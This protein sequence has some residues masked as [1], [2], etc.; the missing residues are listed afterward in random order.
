MAPTKTFRVL[1][2]DGG[3]MRGTY[4]ATYLGRVAADFAKKRGL[5]ELDVGAAFDLVVGTSTGG[6]IA[7]A[8]VA[9]VP[10]ERVAALY[11]DHGKAIFRRPL[12][13]RFGPRLFA[14]LFVRPRAVELGTA[15]LREGLT[16]CFGDTTIEDVYA[17][18]RIALAITAVELS[19]HRSWIFKTPH[20][21]N[22]NGRDNRYTLVNVCLATT[23]APLYRSL[24]AIDHPNAGAPGGYN[25]FADG[26][27]WAN[28]PVLVGLLEALE[29]APPDAKIAIYCLGTCPRPAGE[30]VPRD[31]V[32]R[33]LPEWAF[34]GYAA[35]LSI[36]AHEYAYDNIARML[37]KH[38]NRSCEIVRFPRDQ[39]PA[40]LMPYLGLDD[41][42]PE[43]IDAL[44]N[45]AR[46]DA[47]LTNSVCGDPTQPEGR[48]ICSLFESAPARSSAP[49]IAR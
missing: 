7:C 2:L 23:A 29:I 3:G 12:P 46:S 25:V 43:A 36:D 39:V 24:A 17:R 27:L 48:L 45:Q 20:H 15:T 42:R 31:A 6:I 35:S 40:A 21:P 32:H 11:R 38:V 18:R 5:A 28:N 44:V 19:Q 41:A 10:L 30:Q 22:S 37:A 4:T 1:S 16:A 26:G 13:M 34:G 8:L 9:G 47:N 49:T 14:D 33:G